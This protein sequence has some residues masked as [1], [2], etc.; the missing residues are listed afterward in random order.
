MPAPYDLYPDLRS[1]ADIA[2]AVIAVLVMPAM[3]VLR[4]RRIGALRP[5]S[6][7][8]AYVVTIARGMAMAAAV[9]AVWLS[10]ERDFLA[11]GLDWPVGERGLIGFGIV[12]LLALAAGVQIAML[13]RLKPPGIENALRRIDSLKIMPRNDRELG[14]F[15]L[16]SLSAGIWEEL[17][18]RG[19]LIWFF[20]PWLGPIGSAA[21]ATLIFGLGHAYQGWRG[22]LRTAALG[23]VF[24]AAYIVTG[25]LWWLI[26]THALVD[27]FGGLVTARVRR[28][29]A[30]Q[31]IA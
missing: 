19:F 24:A 3:S 11:L 10:Y 22:I 12:A 21:L 17:L 25:S 20:A 5:A 23:A 31:G 26:A 7:V 9:V 15:L 29:A 2:I 13:S 18:Y 8:P 1:A 30:R 14:F 6:L 28:L 16:V 4:G 27:I